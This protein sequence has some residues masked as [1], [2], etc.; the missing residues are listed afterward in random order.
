MVR[1]KSENHLC[2]G[3][4]VDGFEDQDASSYDSKHEY[5]FKVI[6]HAC[7]DDCKAEVEVIE[8]EKSESFVR[9]PET[10]HYVEQKPVLVTDKFNVSITNV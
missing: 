6:D 8:S 1:N 7:D 9:E 2:C 5:V 10:V 4:A 3:D